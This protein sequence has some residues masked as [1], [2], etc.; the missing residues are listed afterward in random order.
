MKSLLLI[1][2]LPR[3]DAQACEQKEQIDSVNVFFSIPAPS[4]KEKCREIIECLLSIRFCITP[5]TIY[6]IT[7][8]KILGDE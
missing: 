7:F 8:T 1:V 4:L 2:N 5:L 6:N 3:G